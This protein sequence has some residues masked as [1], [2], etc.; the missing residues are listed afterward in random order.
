[1]RDRDRDDGGRF[2]KEHSDEDVLAA[3][4]KHEPAGTAEVAS[5]LGIARQSADFRLRK[6]E[7]E[8]SVSVEKI[9]GSLVWSVLPED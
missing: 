2:Q 3:V 6:L 9:G 7:D 4:R 8:G 5:E 1:M